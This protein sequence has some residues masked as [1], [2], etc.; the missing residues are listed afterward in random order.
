MKYNELMEKVEVT[1]EMHERILTNISEHTS[2]R[3]R[4]V[5]QLFNIRKWGALA[6]CAV[7][8]LLC[9]T[10]LPDVLNHES[11]DESLLAPV[12]D[13]VE[14]ENASELSRQADFVVEDLSNIPF[15]VDEATYTWCFGTTAQIDYTGA[16]NNVSY[17][18]AE[19]DDDISGDYNEYTE[20]QEITIQGIEATVKGNDNKAYVAIWYLDGYSYA[21]SSSEGI[22]YADMINM[23]KSVI[24]T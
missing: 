13:L 20:I 24:C 18:I 3:Q 22:D 16:N 6:A 4:K 23:I 7:I 14:C 12:E 9:V 10:V 11:Q 17:R 15:D 21:I 19:G 8:V 1:D 2:K 5:V